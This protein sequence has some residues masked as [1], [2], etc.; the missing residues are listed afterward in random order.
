MTLGYFLLGYGGTALVLI[1]G[2]WAAVRGGRSERLAVLIVLVG[3]FLTPLV[4]TTYTP[5]LPIFLLDFVVVAALFTIS[6]Y[7]RRI[8]SVL[9]TACAAADLVSHFADVL[10]P[11]GH[12]MA[13]AYVVT[14]DFLGG[15]FVAL[16]LGA[17]AWESEQIRKRMLAAP[18]AH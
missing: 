8:W 3:W 12:K 1:L 2:A 11:E 16:C 5:G 18:A 6:C 10:A 15:I 17:A 4:K 9:I 7:S 14:S 13:W